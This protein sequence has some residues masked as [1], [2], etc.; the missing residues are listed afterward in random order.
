LLKLLY[1]SWLLKTIQ[2]LAMVLILLFHL[3]FTFIILN[4]NVQYLR[5]P[6]NAYHY[7]LYLT[8][9]IFGG[10]GLSMLNILCL[11]Y[12]LEIF[13]PFASL[14]KSGIPL[15]LSCVFAAVLSFYND[16]VF[17]S[18]KAED[19]IYRFDDWKMSYFLILLQFIVFLFCPF[20]ILFSAIK[21]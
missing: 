13:A 1:C 11:F 21:I 15:Y 10:Y 6:I 9:K 19:I 16:Y 17:N 3:R 14:Y 20:I 2:S 8:F 12:M 7:L 5:H 18:E 4:M